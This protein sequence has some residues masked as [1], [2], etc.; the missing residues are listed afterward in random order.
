MPARGIGGWAAAGV[1]LFR[2]EPARDLRESGVRD[3]V[4]REPAAVRCNEAILRVRGCE[5]GGVSYVA[6]LVRAELEVMPKLA[7][8]AAAEKH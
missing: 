5:Q 4:R 3:S 1:V 2:R 7:G 6:R 8:E